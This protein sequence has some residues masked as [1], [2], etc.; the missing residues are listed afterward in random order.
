MDIS[1]FGASFREVFGFTLEA[2][3]S[4]SKAP[5]IKPP[6]FDPRRKPNV[7][8]LSL[9]DKSF[10]APDPQDGAAIL[11]YGSGSVSS[12][13]TFDDLF[14]TE[15]QLVTHYRQMSLYPECDAAIDDVI[16]AM[17]VAEDEKLM[18]S[19][20]LNHLK[21]SDYLKTKIRG[22]FDSII[23]LLKFRQNYYRIAKCWYVDGRL[24][25]H[26]MIDEKNPKAGIK[27]LRYIDPRQVR[28]VRGINKVIDPRT[29][30]PVVLDVNE[31]FLYNP[32]GIINPSM[33]TGIP[34]A[35]D[36]I[37]F[38]NSGELNPH[39]THIISHLHKAIK[40][41][42]QLKMMED[43]VV[44]Y[45]ITRAPERRV[46]YVDVGNL[47]TNRAEQYVKDLMNRFKSRLVYNQ[48]TGEVGDDRR[49][50]AMQEDFWLPRRDG[51]KGTQI[52][53]LKG[54][55]NL[56]EMEDVDYYLRQLY[57]SLN[58]PVSRLDPT[59]GFNLGRS[60]DINRDEDKFADF[61]DRLRKKFS[62][63]FNSLL[64]VQLILK[65]IVTEDGWNEM[66][67]DITYDYLSNSY[68]KEVR[69]AEILRGRLELAEKADA[70]VGMYFSHREV[71]TNILMQSQ[72]T[73]DRINAEIENEKT[74][75]QFS[76]RAGKVVSNMG[77]AGEDEYPGFL[78]P[79]MDDDGNPIPQKEPK[80]KE[81][82]SKNVRRK[83]SSSKYTKDDDSLSDDESDDSDSD[84]KKSSKKKKVIRRVR[85]GKLEL[86][87]ANEES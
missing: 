10:V 63:I 73:I 82:E 14:Q 59:S 49:Y 58:V 3:K 22:E 4:G 80:E 34:I 5:A 6:V 31:F 32:H 39:C 13:I 19:I 41:L 37:A 79:E 60:A 66:V 26:I 56:G 40:P 27:E 75:G 43:A 44:I 11:N 33:N 86:A 21:V 18:V 51:A 64:R 1:F 78:P 57:K 15:N 81:V 12:G 77:R 61:V 52:D 71:K 76:V 65:N 55:E 9:R 72:E 70:Y 45:R 20:N 83:G 84:T 74:A 35:K 17:L 30:A 85:V 8:S 16:N 50:M 47:P 67:E 2:N 53:T 87:S 62:D 29:G 38:A 24:Y 7:S 42:N 69:D 23:R 25:Y 68:Y 54:G 28:F 46:F 36:S 48:A